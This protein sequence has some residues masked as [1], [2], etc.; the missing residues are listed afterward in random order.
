MMDTFLPAIN[1]LFQ[2]TRCYACTA[3]FNNSGADFSL[4]GLF[5]DSSNSARLPGAEKLFCPGCLARINKPPSPGCPLCGE[6]LPGLSRPDILCGECQIRRPPWSAF[7]YFGEYD[8]LLRQ[9]LVSFKFNANLSHGYALSCLLFQAVLKA[10]SGY[11]ALVPIPL[12]N[13][14]LRSRGFN[15]A[16]ELARALHKPLGL[17]LQ[18]D[19][20]TRSVASEPQSG[21]D[22]HSR[23][24]NTR[25]IF[26]ASAGIKDKR[27]LLVDDVMTTG[28]TMRSAVNTLL[29]AGARDVAVAAVAKTRLRKI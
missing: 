29:D 27:I 6:A 26:S 16:H 4:S 24:K 17:P 9:L 25:K 12:H 18:A 14:R 8:D 20:L 22:M 5:S 7:I 2:E 13:A 11:D 15:Q 1:A 19:F 21:L 3:P 23:I 28:A 10:G